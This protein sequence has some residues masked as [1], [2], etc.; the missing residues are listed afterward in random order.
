M[1]KTLSLGFVTLAT[2]AHLSA[3]PQISSGAYAGA[4]AGVSVL[5][6]KYNYTH[7]QNGAQQT[8]MAFSLSKTSPAI[9]VFAGYGMKVSGFW[10]A[11]EIFYQFDSL[12]NKQNPVIGNDEKSISSKATGAYGAAVHLGF[13]P[14]ENCIAYVILGLEARKFKVTFAD[15]PP[16]TMNTQINKS[17][18]SV[19]FAPGVG[20]RFALTKELS[21]RAEYK[22]AMHRNKKLTDTAGIPGGGGSDT[23]TVKHQPKVHTF[24]VGVVYTF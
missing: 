14:A 20:A 5:G 12:K 7:S 21:L 3:A 13:L 23:I 4:A 16:A 19:A 2:A 24:N 1:K 18:T 11:A 17:Y 22:Y 8:A 9:S 10:T 6:G 15:V